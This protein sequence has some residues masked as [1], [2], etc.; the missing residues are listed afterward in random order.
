MSFEFL[1]VSSLEVIGKRFNVL[2]HPELFE[3][4]KSYDVGVGDSSYVIADNTIQS[5]NFGFHWQGGWD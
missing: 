2:P 5:F 4:P 3:I 1:L